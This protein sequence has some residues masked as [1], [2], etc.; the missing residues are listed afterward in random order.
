MW[1]FGDISSICAIDVLKTHFPGSEHLNSMGNFFLLNKWQNETPETA[2]RSLWRFL[3]ITSLMS[4]WFIGFIILKKY[5]LHHEIYLKIMKIMTAA[6]VSYWGGITRKFFP[7]SLLCPR[8]SC[9][10]CHRNSNKNDV[11]F[12]WASLVIAVRMF[13]RRKRDIQTLSHIVNIMTTLGN[14]LCFFLLSAKG[15]CW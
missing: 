4:A 15:D 11:K 9:V 7:F 12:G 2:A 10:S 13:S 3:W 1:L 5:T 14:I 6:N 8:Q